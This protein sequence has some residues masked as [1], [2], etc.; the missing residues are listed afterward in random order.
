MRKTNAILTIIALAMLAP[1]LAHGQARP[2]HGRISE[3]GKLRVLELWGNRIEA[4]YAHGYLLADEIVTLLDNY[5]LD[6]TIVRNPQVYESMMVANVERLFS[7]DAANRAELEALL[8]GARARLGDDFRSEKLGR[9][10]T[11]RDLMVVNVIA[12]WFGFLC[13]SVSVWGELSENGLLRTGR[14]LDFPKTTSMEKGQI[15]LFYRADSRNWAGVTWPGLIG[16]YTGFNADG[17]TMLMHDANGEAPERSAGFVPRSLALREALVAASPKTYLEDVAKVLCNRPVM[18]GNNIHVSGPGETPAGIFEYDGGA[19]T[20]G[21]SLRLPD[22]HES[23]LQ[24]T[25]WCTNHMR[26]RK[27]PDE[28]WRYPRMRRK[29][30]HAAQ[31]DEPITL[32]RLQHI[33][34]QVEQMTT[35]HTVIFEP[36]NRVMHVRIPARQ[37]EP[38]TFKLDEWFSKPIKK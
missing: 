6:E 1:T 25:L 33:M 26:T 8:A 20:Q 11:L 24:D 10:L 34:K 13:S 7:W 12:D 37:E 36:T 18:V 15:V 5:V 2:I 21:V 3:V 17:V 30:N 35:L 22:A 16:V 27:E 23:H 38:V 29:L 4:G 19:T 28:N 31:M 32:A 9:P 14:N